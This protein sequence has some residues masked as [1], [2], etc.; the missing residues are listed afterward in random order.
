MTNPF[1]TIED[2]L[3]NIENLLHDLQSK[4]QNK[5][6][7]AQTAEKDLL[8]VSQTADFLSLAVP[9]IYSMVS[10]GNLPFM[11]R[12]KRIYFSRTELMDYLKAGRKQT[13]AEMVENADQYMIK[14][15]KK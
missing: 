6:N 1:E 14:R 13:T 3:S 15:K 5:G 9:T 4:S 11:K 7:T 12:S 8:T 10:R 2:R